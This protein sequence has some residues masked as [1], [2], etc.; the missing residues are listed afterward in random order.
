MKT[1]NVILFAAALGLG[2]ACAAE[3]GGDDDFDTTAPIDQADLEARVLDAF[4]LL[5][6]PRPEAQENV[7]AIGH[8]RIEID[9]EGDYANGRECDM[10]F[11]GT[12]LPNADQ[13]AIWNLGVGGIGDTSDYP[14]DSRPNM[15]AILA[16]APADRVHHVDG[17]DQFD[18]YHVSDRS[19]FE[20]GQD[21]NGSW[22]VYFVFPG[23]NFDAASYVT[24]TSVEA[25][26]QQVA[27]GILGTPL[28][29]TEA[30]FDPLVLN[31]PIICW[32]H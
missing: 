18:H 17:F 10:Y 9:S 20:R 6:G 24:A 32:R 27:D 2:T 23:P 28:L 14:S 15:Y 11:I 16:P 21:Y 12:N 31:A 3:I 5:Y 26:Q 30:G 22:D 4:D 8:G 25:M 19:S 1:T 7:G 29:T 13:Y